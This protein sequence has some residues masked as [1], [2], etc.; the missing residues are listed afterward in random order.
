MGKSCESCRYFYPSAPTLGQCRRRCRVISPKTGESAFPSTNISDWCGEYE[1]GEPLGS[2]ES[3]DSMRKR[4]ASFYTQLGAA[5]KHNSWLENNKA[6][7]PYIPTEV[8]RGR[9]MAQKVFNNA[10]AAVEA[11]EEARKNNPWHVDKTETEAEKSEKE[12]ARI[13]ATEHDL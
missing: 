8:Q 1:E 7:N 11:Q 9:D 12:R 4:A 3:V 13:N 6:G 5:L 2:E 10:K